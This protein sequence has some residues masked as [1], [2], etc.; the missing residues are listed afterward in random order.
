V[1]VEKDDFGDGYKEE[2]RKPEV[3][4]YRDDDH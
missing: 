4:I 1:D 2:E 3:K